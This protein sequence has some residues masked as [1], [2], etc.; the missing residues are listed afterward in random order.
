MCV[1][2]CVCVSVCVHVYI[3][4]CGSARSGSDPVDSVRTML[5]FQLS[6]WDMFLPYEQDF[7]R[8][9]QSVWAHGLAIVSS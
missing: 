2:V 4:G 1:H 7:L 3:S 6:A 5:T 9:V 8:E